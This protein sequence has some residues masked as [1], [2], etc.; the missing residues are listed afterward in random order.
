MTP[1]SHHVDV[2]LAK[3]LPGI[4]DGEAACGEVWAQ[5][6]ALLPLLAGRDEGVAWSFRSAPMAL[7]SDHRVVINHHYLNTR[8]TDAT[9]VGVK[10][11]IECVYDQPQTVSQ[12]FVFTTR[13]E[14]HVGSG[15]EVTVLGE[16]RLSRAVQVTLLYRRTRLIEAF[17]LER[18][19]GSGRAQPLWE[20]HSNASDWK[21]EPPS[22]IAMGAGE[23]FRWSCTYV[24]LSDATLRVGGAS[25]DAC[26]LLGVYELPD[27]SRDPHPE[28]L[29]EIPR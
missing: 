13:G 2:R 25:S 5:P 28:S 17:S 18:V 10:L 11:N 3:Q 1:H 14:Q 12:S 15:Q 29:S 9:D 26:S 8:S 27:G 23:G 4:A 20:T 16:A 21:F 24:N 22:P 19:D 6:I 7:S